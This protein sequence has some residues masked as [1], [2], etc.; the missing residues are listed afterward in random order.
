[1]NKNKKNKYNLKKFVSN[2]DAMELADA[3]IYEAGSCQ[4]SGNGCTGSCNHSSK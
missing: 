1:M 3:Q 4:N 2:K